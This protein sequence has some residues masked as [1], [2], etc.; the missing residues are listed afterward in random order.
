MAVLEARRLQE[1]DGR[2]RRRR[3]LPAADRRHQLI[4][5]A[6]VV[7]VV[8]GVELR[9]PLDVGLG[10]PADALEPRDSV[11][12][13]AVGRHR[14]V[15]R[16]GGRGVVLERLVV[17]DVVI[18]V[19]PLAG[20]AERGAH[21]V[22]RVAQRLVGGVGGDVLAGEV[23]GEL[24][25]DERR[26]RLSAVA[27]CGRGCRELGRRGKATFEPA[28][29]ETGAIQDVADVRALERDRVARRAIVP[30]RLSVV[31]QGEAALAVRREVAVGS[32][33]RRDRR[34]VC[35]VAG[36]DVAGVARR[37]VDGA[38]RRGP[39]RDTERVVAERVVLGVVPHRGDGVA[40]VVVH[41]L[42]GEA[43]CSERALRAGV[44]A[45]ALDE[46]VHLSVVK[47]L[48]LVAVVVV[49]VT[50][51]LSA[52]MAGQAGGAA[53]QPLG[54]A[55]VRIVGQQVGAVAELRRQRVA[56]RRRETVDR[57]CPVRGVKSLS[58]GVG[59]LGIGAEVVVEG[60]VLLEDHDD[61]LDRRRGAGA[62]VAVGAVAPATVVRSGGRRL[63]DRDAGGGDC[64]CRCE[65]Q[66]RAFVRHGKVSFPCPLDQHLPAELLQHGSSE[67]RPGQAFTICEEL[68]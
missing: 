64:E 49:L 40:V 30:I 4:E 44:H 67:W 7:L 36:V 13:G 15:M 24:V 6:G 22:N 43:R 51:E 32:G 66:E 9:R 18:L 23:P 33:G 58:V 19:A 8:G 31:G 42:G 29:G 25:G 27:G 55:R 53:V 17:R 39:E 59:G 10:V 16:V 11:A 20:A 54:L 38:G 1:G 50:G 12:A 63:R 41:D 21:R 37:D 14:Q 62:V 48:L 2:K 56:R 47:R 61:V 52:G 65:Q 34:V 5:V 45:G 35:L 68:V 46:V 28:P 57:R 60:L 3:Q 26:R